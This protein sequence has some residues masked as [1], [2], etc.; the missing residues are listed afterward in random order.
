MNTSSVLLLDRDTFT[1]RLASLGDQPVAVAQ[2]DIDGFLLVNEEH[3]REVG[4]AVI[5][6]VQAALAANLPRGSFM[7]R[8]GGDEFACA[9]PGAS[10]E[11][12]LIAVEEIRQHLAGRA[13]DVAG[14]RM[15]IRITAGIAAAPHHTD[16]TA[17]LPRLADQAMHRAKLEGGGRVTIFM[18]DKMVLKSN[19]YR[20]AQLARLAA[21]SARLGRTEASLLRDAL[22]ELLQTHR[23][24]C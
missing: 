8:I 1:T 6:V 19:Y 3:G 13:H 18:E 20:R 22:D 7:T 10:P 4:N 24:D 14:E 16:E 21:I 15:P 23:D 11:E 9:I 12:A 17:R 5:A 2:T